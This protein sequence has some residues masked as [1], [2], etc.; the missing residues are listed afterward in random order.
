MTAF[1][2]KFILTSLA[3]WILLNAN[4]QSKFFK[5]KI[6]KEGV[7]HLSQDQAKLIG[8]SSISEVS[9]FGYPGMLPQLVD[10]SFLELQEIPA[11]EKDGKL[12][13]YLSSPHTYSEF[14]GRLTYNHHLFSDS[15]SFLISKTAS[16]KRIESLQG[17]IGIEAPAIFYKWSFLKEEENN[18]LNSGRVW[19]SKSLAPGVTRG[20][21]FPQESNINAPWKLSGILMS[22]SLSA[23]TLTL[24]VDDLIVSSTDFAAIPFSTYGIKGREN[25][26]T[27]DFIP[28]GN[29]ID[30]VR[31]SFQSS[32]VNSS[33]Y[34][35]H[36]G[37][38]APASSINIGEGVFSKPLSEKSTIQPSPGLSVWE[39]S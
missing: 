25:S 7:Y 32:D 26:I 10:S 15:L 9:I 24:A 1:H 23:S 35:N 20:Y 8:A 29:K 37:F 22:Q 12:Y 11:L 36:L 14:E 21:A 3:F 30:R 31:I 38:G 17:K 39:I 16:P 28:V 18:I 34:F 2:F 19:Y 4:A 33:G 6:S 5:F 27:L 13:F